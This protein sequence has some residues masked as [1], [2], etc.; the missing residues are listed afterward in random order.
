MLILVNI[1]LDRQSEKVNRGQ[2]RKRVP[3]IYN[4]FNNCKQQVVF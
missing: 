2:L 3:I 4:D 1:K